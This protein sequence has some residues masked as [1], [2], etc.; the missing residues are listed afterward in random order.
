MTG[1]LESHTYTA[2]IVSPVHIGSGEK[3]SSIDYVLHGKELYIISMEKLIESFTPEQSKVFSEKLIETKNL[4]RTLQMLNFRPVDYRKY[5]KYVVPCTIQ[6]SELYTFVKD[7]RYRP[8][9]PGS[10][11]KGALRTAICY[12]LFNNPR[13]REW[14]TKQIYRRLARRGAEKAVQDFV[15]SI[16]GSEK[17][18][19]SPHYD[20]MKFLRISDSESVSSINLEIPEVSVIETSSPTTYRKAEHRMYA[21]V[22]KQGLT[23]SGRATIDKTLSQE[24]Y[25][26][27]TD[28]FPGFN[29]PTNLDIIK[30]YANRF[31]TD[32]VDQ[33]IKFATSY[34]IDPLNQFYISL[35]ENILQKLD[36]KQFFLKVGWGSGYLATTIGMLLREEKRLFRDIRERFKLG[37]PRIPIFPM[38]RRIL[39]KREEMIPLGWVKITITD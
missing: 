22:M 13:N 21:E 15:E 3:T 1:F 17:G 19:H 35:K 30:S 34:G 20:V 14:L 2:E 28:D 18:R 5:A 9:I 24:A 23:V 12:N 4:S 36:E 31:A 11:I 26:K 39:L 27:Y 38:S 32:L 29:V 10:S 7:V 37:N 6:P 8:Y 25:L 16:F 33:E